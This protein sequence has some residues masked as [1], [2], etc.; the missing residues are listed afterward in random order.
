MI[1]HLLPHQIQKREKED[2]DQVDDMPEDTDTFDWN[3]VLRME[4][5][6][7]RADQ[8]PSDQTHSDQNVQTMQ[9]CH[10]EIETEV[11]TKIRVLSADFSSVQKVTWVKT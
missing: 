1:R 6:A 11:H 10:R 4:V 2:P 7:N 8:Q 9:T 3:P 5:A